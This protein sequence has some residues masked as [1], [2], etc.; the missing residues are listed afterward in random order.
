METINKVH[1]I[2]VHIILYLFSKCAKYYAK[3][4]LFS[5][6]YVQTHCV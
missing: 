1:G 5:N 6:N 4:V 2:S 3:I